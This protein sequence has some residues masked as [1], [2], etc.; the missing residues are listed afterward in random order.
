ML[1][2]YTR[3]ELKQLEGKR[4]RTVRTTEWILEETWILG[5]GIANSW[6]HYVSVGYVS[7]AKGRIQYHQFELLENEF[8]IGEEVEVSDDEEVRE[9]KRYVSTYPWSRLYKHSVF[10]NDREYQKYKVWADY[11]VTDYQQ[12]RKIQPKPEPKK[13]TMEELNKE[14]WYEVEI[15][16]K[17]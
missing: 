14:L 15:V 4:V 5:F 11:D 10:M 1:K 17:K 8:E 6:L 7:I 9:P 13:M 16:E 3:E 2:T 12:I